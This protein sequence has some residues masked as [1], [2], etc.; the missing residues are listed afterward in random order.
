MDEKKRISSNSSHHY[1]SADTMP[2]PKRITSDSSQQSKSPEM[3][4]KKPVVISDSLKNIKC[5]ADISSIDRDPRLRFLSLN[6]SDGTEV[7][8]DR[9][10]GPTADMLDST[11]DQDGDQCYMILVE[12][13]DEKMIEWL[14]QLAEEI[15]KASDDVS[16]K[17]A[18]QEGTIKVFLPAL[19]TGYRLYEQIRVPVCLP[20]PP[21]D[22]YTHFTLG[23][24]SWR[25]TS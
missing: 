21:A 3:K 11:P 8:R 4:R 2:Q 15:V 13:K 5:A 6:H 23:I 1:K 7:W 17:Q 20:P 25:T 9:F 24:R 22:Q 12:L 18:V 10:N 19:P 14:K 16:I